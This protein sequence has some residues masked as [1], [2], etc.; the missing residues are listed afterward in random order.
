MTSTAVGWLDPGTCSG[1]FAEAVARLTSYETA[2]GRFRTTL[3]IESGPQMPE[4][5]NK[6]VRR[7]L[8]ETDADWLLMVDSDMV[9]RHDALERLIELATRETVHSFHYGVA[10]PPMV[11][12]LCYGLRQDIGPFPTL[13][14]LNDDGDT[15]VH[16]HLPAS[17]VRVDATGAAFLLMHRTTLENI[18]R[19][20]PHPW[21]HRR[22]TANGQGWFGEDISFCLYA[23]EQGV[24]IIVDPDV[25]IGHVKRTV[26]D[27]PSVE[28]IHGSP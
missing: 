7:F 3:R 9:F 19:D 21:F 11:G 28:R 20:D 6:I 22:Q 5:R 10:W 25:I 13:Y 14:R 4:G 8:D 17:P 16:K 12:G 27:R 2:R 1:A 15:E 24:E 23:R 26:I 18:E